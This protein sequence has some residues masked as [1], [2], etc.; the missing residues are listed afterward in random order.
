MVRVNRWF[1]RGLVG[2]IKRPLANRMKN[3]ILNTR[4]SRF[5]RALSVYFGGE[6]AELLFLCV[7]MRKGLLIECRDEELKCAG[8]RRMWGLRDQDM[9]G[10]RMLVR[11]RACLLCMS[12]G[13]KGRGFSMG[14]PRCY[15]C[16]KL[17]WHEDAFRARKEFIAL[18]ENKEPDIAIVVVTGSD[19]RAERFLLP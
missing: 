15:T 13:R 5:G 9:E 8:G 19:Y 11:G 6:S 17:W 1:R 7:A 4:F 2:K 16:M 12:V 3:A 14:E 18:F 10:G